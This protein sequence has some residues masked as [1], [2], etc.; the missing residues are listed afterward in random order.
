MTG[1]LQIKN[2]TYYAVLN[3]RNSEGKRVQKW[4]NLYI[5]VKDN[6]RRAEAALNELLVQYQD[7]E[8]IEP[9]NLLVSRL[10]AQWLEMNR[11]NI[12]VTTYD[13]YYLI[14]NKHITPYFDSKKMTVSKLTAGDLEDYYAFKVQEGLSPNSVIKHHAM[15]RTALQWAVKHRLIRENV[16]DFAQKPSHVRYHGAEPYT[17]QEVA[18]LLQLT[19]N[20]PI[21]VPIFLASFYGMRRSELLGLRWSA[22]NF[23]QGT[24]SISTTVVR[25]KQGDK[26]NP[27]I[28]DNTTKSESSMRTLPLCQYTFQ[29]FTWLLNHRA[30]QRAL[31]GDSYD[32]RYLDFVCVDEMGTL[33]QPDF[34]THKFGQVLKKYGLRPIRFHDL[35]HS[36]A[37]I[38]LYLGYT[39]KDIQTWLGH[40]NYNFT[41]DTYIHSGNDAHEKMAESFAEKLGIVLPQNILPGE[42]PGL[43]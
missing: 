17:I 2:D 6:K 18:N 16:A 14:L 21:A 26:I 8:N 12:A 1:S 34:I 15:I 28:R 38:M 41:A 5:P 39:L 35:R 3:F 11:P 10:V 31:C 20:E 30:S 25:E 9:M 33:L 13:Q 36:C 37:T 43:C 22:I 7:Y 40:S 27:V 29:Y 42:N 19:A 23:Q 32:Q 4:M 24:L